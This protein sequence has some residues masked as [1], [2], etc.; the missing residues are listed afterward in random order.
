MAIASLSGYGPQESNRA[1]TAFAVQ[2]QIIYEMAMYLSSVIVL[3]AQ[4]VFAAVFNEKCWPVFVIGYAQ[5]IE[6][7]AQAFVHIKLAVCSVTLAVKAFLACLIMRSELTV[8]LL[9]LKTHVYTGLSLNVS[10]FIVELIAAEFY[11]L[12]E[13]PL[14]IICFG[15]SLKKS[16]D[17]IVAALKYLPGNR[18]PS[19]ALRQV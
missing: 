4:D 17:Y 6:E 8:A 19:L 12:F 13:I 18:C 3:D 5:L 7:L 1:C 2:A 16:K 11:C 9:E 14:T 15:I 10:D